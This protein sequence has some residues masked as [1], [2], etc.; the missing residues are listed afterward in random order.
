LVPP[1]YWRASK[2]DILTRLGN[3]EQE[4]KERREGHQKFRE[5]HE[6]L[7]K[8][9]EELRA[10]TRNYTKKTSVSELKSGGTRGRI[11]H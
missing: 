1:V 3:L 9:N 2:E 10:K 8:E 7:R 4:L 6:A 5:E 11:L